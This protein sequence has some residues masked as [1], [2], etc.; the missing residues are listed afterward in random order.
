M[1]KLFIWRERR[2]KI[3]V[4]LSSMRYSGLSDMII[5]KRTKITMDFQLCQNKLMV[6]FLEKN[7]V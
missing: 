5:L 7:D 3:F 4:T 2:K 6:K 1:I